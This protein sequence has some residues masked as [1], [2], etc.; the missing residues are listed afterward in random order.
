MAEHIWSNLVEIVEA[1]EDKASLRQ[2]AFGAG[3]GPRGD[4]P[5]PVVCL[6]AVR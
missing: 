3:G 1:A 2:A 4:L 6:I 5:L